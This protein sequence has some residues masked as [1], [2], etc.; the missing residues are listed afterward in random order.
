MA[1][2]NL[3][4]SKELGAK[5]K[6][7]REQWK[8]SLVEVS[9][10]LEIDETELKGIE[11]G[12]ILPTEQLLDLI[13]NHFHLSEEQASE[14]HALAAVNHAHIPGGLPGNSSGSI[15]EMLMKQIVMYM[16]VDNRVVYTDT[17]NATV[18]K[19]GMV[20]QFLQSQNGKSVPVSQVGMSREHAEKMLKVIT[21]TL[22]KYDNSQQT[23]LLSP[24]SN[25]KDNQKSK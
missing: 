11:S 18:N 15:E 21:T 23:K 2:E 19:H 3:N 17:M 24:P 8:Q 25:D 12:K 16:P 14:L 22:E 7:L 20:L 5:I 10:T 13:I 9:T 4:P 6:R 1:K